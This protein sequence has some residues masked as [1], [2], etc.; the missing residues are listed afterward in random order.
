[1]N[2]IRI[3]ENVSPSGANDRQD[4]GVRHEGP[5]F[6]PPTGEDEMGFLTRRVSWANWQFGPLKMAMLSLGVVV[7]AAFADFWKPYLWP[8][9]LV[10]LVTTSWATILWVGDMRRSP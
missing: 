7:G 9:G 4:H 1:M 5:E 10:G 6:R 2:A 3:G 8:V